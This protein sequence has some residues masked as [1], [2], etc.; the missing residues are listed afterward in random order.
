MKKL[1]ISI[2][3][4]GLINA[5]AYA[6]VTRD[7]ATLKAD[8]HTYQE[9]TDTLIDEI[10]DL[11]SGFS[12]MVVDDSESHHG[13]GSAASKVYYSKSPLSIGGYGE[14]YWANPDNGDN[15]ADV[16]RF[17]PYI[18]YRFSDNIILNTEIE[19][20]HGGESVV[21]EFLYLDFLI[22][23][24]TNIRLGNLLVP[25]GLINLRH[26][27]TLFNTIQRPE[28]ERYLIPSTWHENG[29]LV[30][31]MIAESDFEYTVG[32]VN[33][34]DLKAGNEA[35]PTQWIR[36]GRIGSRNKGVMNRVAVVGRLDY[37]GYH[38]ALIGVS[39]YYG[40]AAQGA[41]SGS[42][43]L[44]YDVHATYE[45]RGM[46]AKGV[47]TATSITGAK[48]W[49]LPDAATKAQGYYL[50]IEYD[51]LHTAATSLRLPLF[52]QYESYDPT[53]K[54][55]GTRQ[56]SNAVT[57]MTF[58]VNVFPHEQV[59]LK[60]DY[61]MKNYDDDNQKDYHTLSLGLGFIF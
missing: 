32:L 42:S 30:Y 13:M 38:G 35:S 7:I 40:D 17:I 33:A 45:T 22:N 57:N 56:R 6:D 2:A 29:L 1:F 52:V 9:M 24:H 11:K 43:A 10:S 50:N 18:G 41:V 12:Y 4:L 34:L 48:E 55:L 47:F 23:A 3:A 39:A 5:G 51:L 25:M 20:E 49:N 44:M 21:I 58:G 19:F 28:L 15:F 46:K 36:K 54:T 14:M 8:L 16:Y 61:T 59:V 31:G 27:P 37:R 53:K 26:E 60:V